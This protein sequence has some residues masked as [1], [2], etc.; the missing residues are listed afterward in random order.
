M[1]RQMA[2]DCAGLLD[3]LQIQSAHVAGHSMG[4][5]IAQ[6]LTLA[7]RTSGDSFGESCLLEGGPREEM[8]EAMEASVSVEVERS[9]LDKVI[10][11]CSFG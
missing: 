7:Y 2:D 5:Q 9:A 11:D 6:E 3:V 1:M 8:A 4:G 10:V